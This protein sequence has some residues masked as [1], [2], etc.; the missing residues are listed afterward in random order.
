MPGDVL[1]AVAGTSSDTSTSSAAASP[2]LVTVRRYST[3]APSG[4]WRPSE[5]S[6]EAVPSAATGA[7]V[8]STLRAGGATRRLTKARLPVEEPSS[9]APSSVG[10]AA[11]NPSDG[12]SATA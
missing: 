1:V 2:V 11:V 9:T 10:S 3:V 4:T 12:S 6:P 7:W 5:V 8:F